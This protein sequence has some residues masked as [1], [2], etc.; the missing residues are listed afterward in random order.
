[1]HPFVQEFYGQPM[2]LVVLGFMRYDPHD[3]LGFLLGGLISR[4]GGGAGEGG[5]R[6]GRRMN[7]GG[8]Q[9]VGNV[10][11]STEPGDAWEPR[12]HTLSHARH[13]EPTLPRSVHNHPT[14]Q[15]CSS[16]DC[17]PSFHRSSEILVSQQHNWEIQDFKNSRTTPFSA[18]AD[19]FCPVRIGH[20]DGE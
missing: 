12:P 9:G 15:R 13:R 14:G 4:G 2:Q 17:Q 3:G 11:G 20:Y 1:M 7:A 5:R 19:C 18:T 16:R 6:R 8:E 10:A